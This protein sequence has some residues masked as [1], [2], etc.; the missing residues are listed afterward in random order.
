MATN[1]KIRF[2]TGTFG[3]GKGDVVTLKEEDGKYIYYY[4]GFDRWCYLQKREEGITFEYLAEKHC[5]KR[6]EDDYSI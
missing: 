4:D 5:K 1:R 3:N 6:G 2:L